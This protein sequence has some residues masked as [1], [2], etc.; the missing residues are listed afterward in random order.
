MEREKGRI[1][2]CKKGRNDWYEEKRVEG[3]KKGTNKGWKM[4]M[5]GRD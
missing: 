4:E 3:G 1:D 2:G 5:V